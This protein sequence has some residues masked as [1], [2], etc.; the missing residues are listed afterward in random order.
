MQEMIK[1]T[2]SANGEHCTI[3]L[4]GICNHNPDT[5]VFCHINGIRHGHGVGVKTHFGAYGCSSCHDAID[6]RVKTQYQAVE[7]KN[8]LYEAVLETLS[9]LIDKGLVKYG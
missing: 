6:G 8:A 9:K 2:K 3:R 5:V 4:P 7:L 1:I